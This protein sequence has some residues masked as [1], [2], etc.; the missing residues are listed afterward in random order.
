MFDNIIWDSAEQGI[1][2]QGCAFTYC[3]PLH[4]GMVIGLMM[5]II[6]IVLLL[7]RQ[8]EQHP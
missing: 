8:Q 6:G 4:V 5:A 2:Y 1:C 3:N 7:I